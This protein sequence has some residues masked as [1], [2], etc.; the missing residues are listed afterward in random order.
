MVN[1]LNILVD[2]R[3]L[4]IAERRE[5]QDACIICFY[6]DESRSCPAKQYFDTLLSNEKDKRIISK[7]RKYLKDWIK[8]GQ[9]LKC[10]EHFRRIPPLC[11]LKAYR[12]RLLIFFDEQICVV[13][14]G[15]DKPNKKEQDSE[16]KRGKKIYQEYMRRK[17]SLLGRKS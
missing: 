1:F 12:G 15:F 17:E 4:E 16:I 2:N 6:L 9:K 8:T 10:P 14:N 7:F 3:V 13:A 5:P 11:E